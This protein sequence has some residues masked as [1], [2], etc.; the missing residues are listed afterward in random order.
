MTEN[1]QRKVKI[2]SVL[3]VDAL[4]KL[5]DEINI[6]ICETIEDC[7]VIDIKYSTCMCMDK[8]EYAFLASA[9]VIYI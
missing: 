6:F 8:G 9:M 2:F 5:D 3:E 4:E 7:Q 1:T